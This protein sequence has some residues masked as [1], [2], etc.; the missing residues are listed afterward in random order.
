MLQERSS[1]FDKKASVAG[2][3]MRSLE[4]AEVARESLK[5][6][7]PPGSQLKTRRTVIVVCTRRG[8]LQ[9]HV[10]GVVRACLRVVR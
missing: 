8:S 1:D 6:F 3:I 10:Q 5:S 7:H 2:C 9:K 4:S